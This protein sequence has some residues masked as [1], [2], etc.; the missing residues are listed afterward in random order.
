MSPPPYPIRRLQHV[1]IKAHDGDEA[2]AFYRDVMGF[3][4]SDRY[5]PGD[6]PRNPLGITF[7]R[8]GELHHELSILTYSK[9]PVP[10]PEAGTLDTQDVGLHHLAFEVESKEALDAWHEYIQSKGIR[11]VWGPIVH[12]P[13]HPD[14]HGTQGENRAFYFHDPSGNGIGIFTDMALLDPDTNRVNEEWYRD[15]LER[16]G[17]ARDAADP[18]PAWAPGVSSMDAAR[19]KFEND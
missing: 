6:D 4:I 16:D 19:H 12:S 5:E 7:M 11:I 15:R 14:G 3:T 13:T 2:V 9:D 8:S 10:R 18:P 17:F 1:G